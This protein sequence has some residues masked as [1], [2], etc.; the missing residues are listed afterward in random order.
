MSCGE[1]VQVRGVECTPVG[2][3]CDPTTRPEISRSCSTGISCP[4]Y[5]EADES[6]VSLYLFSIIEIKSY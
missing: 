2:G 1:G 6:D 5:R 3:G 4:S